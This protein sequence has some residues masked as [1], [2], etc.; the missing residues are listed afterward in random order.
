MTALLELEH[1]CTWYGQAQVL[2]DVSLEVGSGEIVLLLGRNGA[3]KSTSL[4]SIMGLRPARS[5][6]I[7]FEERDITRWPAH[8]IAHAGIGYVPEDRR[9]FASLSVMDNLRVAA[10]ADHDGA[11]DWTHE[12]LFEVFPNLAGMRRRLGSQM[13]GGEQQMLT[14]ARTL[15]GQPRLLLLDEPSEGLAPVIVDAL[16]DALVELKKTGLAILLCEQNDSFARALAD[17]AYV[18]ES[19]QIRFAGTL[20]ALHADEDA[21]RAW[22]GV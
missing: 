4:R 17:R 14:I 8:R 15:M 1:V 13:S 22:L 3:G 7:R 18:M 10:R 19:G 9:V 5:G 11:A 20:E 21:R 2:F 6:S 16:A 12:R